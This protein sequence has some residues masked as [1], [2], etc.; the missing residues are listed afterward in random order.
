MG[1]FAL[2]AGPVEHGTLKEVLAAEE[3]MLSYARAVAGRGHTLVDV[4]GNKLA[5]EV[6][7]DYQGAQFEYAPSFPR[8][9]LDGILI[10]GNVES[11]L[12]DEALASGAP[13]GCLLQTLPPSLSSRAD[14]VATA[15]DTS[16]DSRQDR[17]IPFLLQ[18]FVKDP[19][20]PAVSP[21]S[22]V[23][24]TPARPVSLDDPLGH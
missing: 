11:G 3:G 24:P 23:A 4:G 9:P 22:Q 6:V 2:I 14:L 16:G 18:R 20:L 8:D 17:A 7:K 10:I 21:L 5:E 1:C 12:V 19:A 13:L 15:L